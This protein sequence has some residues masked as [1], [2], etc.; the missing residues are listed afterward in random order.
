MKITCLDKQV[1]QL[2]GKAD[3]EIPRFQR[4]YTWDHV[5]V[6]EFWNDAVVECEGNYF[7]GNFV[8]YDDKGVLGVVDGQQRLTTITLLLCALR[9]VF[10]EQGEEKLAK[11]LH[12]LIERPNIQAEK[13]YVLQSETSYPYFQEHIQKFQGKPGVKAEVGPEEELLKE[14]FDY[15]REKLDGIVE[16]IENQPNLSAQKRLSEFAKNFLK[17]GTRCWH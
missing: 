17:S 11:G 8:V 2:L 14:A 13:Y 10:Q 12:G 1:G 15:L 4:P 7:I 6:E 9:D 3:Y 16:A 5:N